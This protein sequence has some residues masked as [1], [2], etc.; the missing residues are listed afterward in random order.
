MKK[1]AKEMLQENIN[2][3]LEK[4]GT[5][6]QS[7]EYREP[8]NAVSSIPYQGNN[9]VYL[10]LVA[11]D[12]QYGSDVWCTMKQANQLGRKVIA[13]EKGTWITYYKNVKGSPQPDSEENS[14][15]YRVARAYLVF[16]I[17]QT[18]KL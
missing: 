5:N 15:S 1:S 14:K 4:L 13:G 9:A 16:N 17:E 8:I 7:V 2:N 11:E 10:A 18:V 6:S 3:L 12:K